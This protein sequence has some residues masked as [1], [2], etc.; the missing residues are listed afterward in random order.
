MAPGSPTRVQLSGSPTGVKSTTSFSANIA[1][2][3]SPARPEELKTVRKDVGAPTR[4]RSES[5]SDGGATETALA[6]LEETYVSVARVL[7]TEGN[8]ASAD[9]D[10]DYFEHSPNKIDL[11]D[12]TKE[13]AF[14]PDLTEDPSTTID[15]EAANVVNPQLTASQQAQLVAVLKKHKYIMIA[16]GNALPPP[17]YGVVCDIDVHGHAPIKQR[18]YSTS[19]QAL[20]LVEGATESWSNRVL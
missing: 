20:R 9:R 2:E 1:N 11:E 17:A 19:R 14:L 5:S 15:Y 8:E 12:Y 4:V 7:S 3:P 10:M 6:T 13:L 16:S 18:A